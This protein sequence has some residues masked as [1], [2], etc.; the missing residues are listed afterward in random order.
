MDT[1][2]HESDGSEPTSEDVVER[3]YA[4]IY[5]LAIGTNEELR[6]LAETE[7][8]IAPEDHCKQPNIDV[9][10]PEEGVDEPAYLA[11]DIQLLNA[12]SA[13]R[14]RAGRIVRLEQEWVELE[15]AHVRK[16]IGKLDDDLRDAIIDH[17]LPYAFDAHL[18][19]VGEEDYGKV[20]EAEQ[21]FEQ[22]KADI[23][24]GNLYVPPSGA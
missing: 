4:R 1:L 15:P 24:S 7:G 16:I 9:M 19:V 21:V 3:L 17:V 8:P 11:I 23:R 5:Q 2:Q 14:R 10:Y 6:R 12:R 20:L 22:L 18:R 13:V